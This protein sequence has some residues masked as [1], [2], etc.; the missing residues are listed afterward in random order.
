L[1]RW[2]ENIRV[3][4]PENPADLNEGTKVSLALIKTQLKSGVLKEAYG[5]VEGRAGY[6]LSGD[7][8]DEPPTEN[9]ET[10]TPYVSFELLRAVPMPRF[11]EI[12]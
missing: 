4:P 12:H 1:G 3:L 5:F 9:L 2:Q 11:S 8:P 10:R 6:F 7:L